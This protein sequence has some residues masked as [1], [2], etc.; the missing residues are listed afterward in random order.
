[1]MTN[2]VAVLKGYTE[3]VIA[4]GDGINLSLLIKPD[5]DIDDVFKAWDSDEQEF[6]NV[7]GWMFTFEEVGVVIET[8]NTQA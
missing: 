7:N 3:E 2:N 4:Y 1:M 6:V 8:I 5:T